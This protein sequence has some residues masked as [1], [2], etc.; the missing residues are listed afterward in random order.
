MTEKVRRRCA[1]RGVIEAEQ[2]LDSIEH[3]V[4][5]HQAQPDHRAYVT[6][7]ELADEKLPAIP[8]FVAQLKRVA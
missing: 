2:D 1:C 7:V 5:V 4:R 8:V 6:A 3:A